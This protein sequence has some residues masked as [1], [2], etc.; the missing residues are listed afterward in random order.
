AKNGV[1]LNLS[2]YAYY[3]VNPSDGSLIAKLSLSGKP[4]GVIACEHDGEFISFDSD[5]N[6]RLIRL[7][8][9]E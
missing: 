3:E 2:D 9:Q 1:A 7:V 6:H 8:A 5:A 4:T